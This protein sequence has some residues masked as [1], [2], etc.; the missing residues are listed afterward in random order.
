MEVK[1][2]MVA[3]G[4]GLG[5]VGGVQAIQPELVEPLSVQYVAQAEEYDFGRALQ[6]VRDEIGGDYQVF[7]VLPQ[8]SHAVTPSL[9]G[10][11][12]DPVLDGEGFNFEILKDDRV[13][14]YYYT[15]M[16]GEQIWL[17]GN[18]TKV[19]TDDGT[20]GFGGLTYRGEG[21]SMRTR[22]GRV[23]QTKMVIVGGFTSC[24]EGFVGLVNIET[25]K[26]IDTFPIQK[27]TPADTF[28]C[29]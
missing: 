4:L 1:E 23:Y 7:K 11:W 28:G 18:G 8:T 15:Y 29:K 6:R 5:V 14:F 3:V 2:V 16:D 27:I 21:G 26:L 22:K 10:S 9:S 19:T 13:V 20:P 17:A 24:M 25:D 12:Y